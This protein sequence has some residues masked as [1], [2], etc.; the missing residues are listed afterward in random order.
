MVMITLYAKQKKRHTHQCLLTSCFHWSLLE[1]DAKRQS[2]GVPASH[3][4]LPH[5]FS[6][7]T[8]P[9][10]LNSASE[11]SNNLSQGDMGV[12]FCDGHYLERR[13]KK[14]GKMVTPLC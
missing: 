5:P 13:T 3:L 11:T 2:W 10:S 12:P 9:V 8:K 1:L 14:V 6:S 4:F 7:C